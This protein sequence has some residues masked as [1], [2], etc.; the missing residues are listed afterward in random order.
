[1]PD[2]RNDSSPRIEK[3]KIQRDRL[4]FNLIEK[5]VE[6]EQER[7]NILDSKASNIIGYVGLIIGLLVTVISFIFGDLS[8]N[9]EIIKYYSSYRIILLFGIL[10]LLGSIVVSIHAYFVREYQIVPSTKALIENYAKEDRDITTILRLVSQE[11]SDV[12]YD[13]KKII[14]DK[15][16]SIKMSLTFLLSEWD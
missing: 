1:M 10:F 6:S 15:A 13:N 12:L 3:E 9:E 16:K 5:R 7:S 11:M 14:D 2:E 8:Q 4:I